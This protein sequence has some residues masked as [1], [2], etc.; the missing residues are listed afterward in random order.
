[1]AASDKIVAFLK[2]HRNKIEENQSVPIV[3]GKKGEKVLFEETLLGSFDTE[4]WSGEIKRFCEEYAETWG[5]SHVITICLQIEGKTY[6]GCDV[7]V[8]SENDPISDSTDQSELSYNRQLIAQ[9]M[10]YADLLVKVLLT[11]HTLM[12]TSYQELM[13]EIRVYRKRDADV[14]EQRERLFRINMQREEQAETERQ[15]RAI[16]KEIFDTVKSSLPMALAHFGTKTENKVVG[17]LMIEQAMKSL[18]GSIKDDQ[19]DLI[20]KAFTPQ[21]FLTLGPLLKHF[22]EQIEQ[23]KKEVPEPDDDDDDSDNEELD[24]LKTDLSDLAGSITPGQM[25]ELSEVFQ[26][27][28]IQAL[29]KLI[30]KAKE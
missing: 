6:S 5:G 14:F 2:K 9:N 13:K 27:E 4:G 28:Q 3:I 19:L 7:R 22:K 23:E 12:Q 1:M 10:K 16:Q 26:P 15:N 24:E 21:Q 8:K 29:Q 25:L 17:N 20:V 30:T 11:P 18:A